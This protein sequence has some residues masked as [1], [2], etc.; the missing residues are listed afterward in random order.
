MTTN[1]TLDQTNNDLSGAFTRR[2]VQVFTTM[3][4]LVGILFLSAGKL[5]WVWGW[6]YLAVYVVSLSFNA[7]FL[8]RISPETVAERGKIKSDAKRWDKLLGILI[9]IPTL[10]SL[11]VAGLDERFGWGPELPTALHIAGLAVSLLGGV[12]FNWALISNAYFS[13]VVRI[14]SDRGH[15]VATNGPYRFIRHPGYVGM[16]LSLPGTLIM[17]GSLWALI[18]AALVTIAYIIRT[19]LEDKTLHEELPGYREYAA[20]TRYRLLPGIW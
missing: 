4:L 2:I 12:L 16:L 17:L 8:L 7:L 9:G 1:T 11:V 3:F 10:A 19:A 14:Q 20:Q 13:R 5:N 18:P 6:V 15:A